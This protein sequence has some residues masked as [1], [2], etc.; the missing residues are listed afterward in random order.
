MGKAKSKIS[1]L[2]FRKGDYDST[3][4]YAKQAMSLAST[5]KLP[6]VMTSALLSLG[7]VHYSKFEDIDAIDHY[8]K[9]RSEERRVGKE[10]ER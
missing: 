8:Q 4:Y 9:I 1:H 2:Y 5:N 7:N 6:E 3:T 10:C